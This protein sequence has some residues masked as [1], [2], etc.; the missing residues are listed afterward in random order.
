MSKPEILEK[1]PMNVTLVKEAL[2]KIRKRDNDELNFRATRTEEYVNEVA[3]LKPKDAKDLV[4]K[5]EKLNIPR[6]KPE[7]IHKVTDVLPKNE[8]HLKVI[9]Q[10]YTLSISAENQKKIMGVVEE[11]LPKK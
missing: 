11:Y 3:R 2:K 8:K 10:G 1:S 6:L 5:L 4:E 9:L 7:I